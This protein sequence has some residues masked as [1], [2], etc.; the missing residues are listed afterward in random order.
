MGELCRSNSEPR[1][2]YTYLILL[3]GRSASGTPLLTP[4]PLEGADRGALRALKCLQDCHCSGDGAGEVG[5]MSTKLGRLA[6]GKFC[7]QVVT[8]S[9]QVQSFGQWQSGLDSIKSSWGDLFPP[10]KCPSPVFQSVRLIFSRSLHHRRRGN[11]LHP[12]IEPILGRGS[13]HRRTHLWPFKPARHIKPR[14]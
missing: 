4:R 8:N 11:C 9:R 3:G 1:D 14:A 10:R 13:K 12:I 5:T 7:G 2:H 6:G